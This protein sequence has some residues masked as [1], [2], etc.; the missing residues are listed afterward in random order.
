MRSKNFSYENKT[1][2]LSFRINQESDQSFSWTNLSSGEK[3][4]IIQFLEVLLQESKSVIFI[5][6]EPEISLHV[7]WQEK[8]LKAIRNL[9]ENAQL[10]IATHSPDIVSDF[11][12]KVLDMQEVVSI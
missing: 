12:D 10:I 3:Q 11:R 2:E 7:I 4:L 1:G 6:D 8:L 9:N 5:A